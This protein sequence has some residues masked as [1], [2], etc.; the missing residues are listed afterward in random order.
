MR[1]ALDW[2][3][4]VT[5]DRE[6]WLGFI[7][8]ATERGHTVMVVTSR[9]EE[10]ADRIR[11]DVRDLG[12]RVIATDGKPKIKEADRQYEH[13]FDVWI[14]DMPHLLFSESVE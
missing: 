9:S 13:F 1:I 3:G 11:A 5:E 4:T 7:K 8:Q 14:D 2:D 10:S 6:L 12:I